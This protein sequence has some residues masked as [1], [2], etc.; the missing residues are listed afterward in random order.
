MPT[1]RS[2]IQQTLLAGPFLSQAFMNPLA[3]GAQTPSKEQWYWYPGH[4]LTI[5]ADGKATGGVTT[6]MLVENSPHEGVPFHKH[7]HE[8]ESFYVIDGEFEITIGDVT[9][10]GG[11][12]SFAY[13]PRN[14]QHRWTNIGNRRGRLLNVF[15]P[16]GIEDYFLAAALPIKNP[17]DN[18][19]VDVA[20]L[21]ARTAP[22]REKF[23]IIRT[24]GLKFPVAAPIFK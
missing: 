21:Q 18:P 7:L 22:L 5:K 16:S 24:G 12:G 19:H 15:N 23:G 8:D 2:L 13:G 1:R 20:E 3:A 9:T 11:P 17:T 14:L 6:W 10:M 4:A